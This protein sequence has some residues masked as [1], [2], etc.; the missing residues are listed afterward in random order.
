MNTLHPTISMDAAPRVLGDD[1]NINQVIP[2]VGQVE[3]GPFGPDMRQVYFTTV[4]H[5]GRQVSNRRFIG[6]D[7]ALYFQTGN[8]VSGSLV[9]VGA[10]E[11]LWAA[12]IDQD[13][14]NRLRES[15]GRL[16][17]AL[18]EAA[19]AEA[20]VRSI[21][22][23]RIFDGLIGNSSLAE[24]HETLERRGGRSVLHAIISAAKSAVHPVLSD[25][26]EAGVQARRRSWDIRLARLDRQRAAL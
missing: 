15:V 2:V 22:G 18:G 11:G 1:F 4:D 21:G 20:D 17:T 14:A 16:T 8:D 19:A 5:Q 23:Q 6:G 24:L 13:N 26:I 25:S 12:K 10:D 3:S 9:T 7:D